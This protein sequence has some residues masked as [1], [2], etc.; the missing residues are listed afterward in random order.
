MN[1]VIAVPTRNRPDALGNCTRAALAHEPHTRILIVDQSDG[2]HA[3]SSLP[4]STLITH[5]RSF[6]SGVS[7]ARNLALRLS[8]ADIVIFVD[9]DCT[10]EPGLVKAMRAVFKDESVGMAFGTVVPAPHDSSDGYIVGFQPRRARLIR[11]SLAKVTDSGIGACMAIRVLAGRE[12]GF[13][14]TLGPGATFPSCEE[15]DLALR[16]LQAGWSVAHVPDAQVVHHGFRPHSNGRVAARETWRGIAAAYLK[17]VRSGSPAGVVVYSCELWRV[18]WG[19]SSRV[20]TLRR[21]FGVARLQGFL[22]G[23][24]VAATFPLDR[25]RCLY[26]TEQRSPNRGH[27]A[28]QSSGLNR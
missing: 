27:S 3:N 28:N 2:A 14:E 13:D 12:Q 21:P 6:E 10:V 20:I 11:H 7:K 23:S 17:H 1:I 15:G 19:V 4:A 18:A 24:L 5:I 9:D 8:D 16:M 26:E 22:Q 25:C